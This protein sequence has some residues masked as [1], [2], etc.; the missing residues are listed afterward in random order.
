MQR[1]IAYA[2][3]NGE[4]ELKTLLAEVQQVASACKGFCEEFKED[5][6]KPRYKWSFAFHDEYSKLTSMKFR[7][8]QLLL[9]HSLWQDVTREL[10]MNLE[11]ALRLEKDGDV[12]GSTQV[13]MRLEDNLKY[14]YAL[15]WDSDL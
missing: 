4:E 15:I 8:E 13:R 14:H 7:L 6:Q 5:L 3:R 9:L 12:E 2:I 11:G 1:E 10:K